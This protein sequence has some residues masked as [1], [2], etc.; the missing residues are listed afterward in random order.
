MIVKATNMQAVDWESDYQT[1]INPALINELLYKAVPALQASSWR[2]T[3]V[4]PGYCE[5]LLPLNEATTN[6]HGTHQAALIS[7][8]A[9]YTG[10]MALTTLLRGVPLS[11]IHHCQPAESAS[12]WLASMSVRYLN[13]STGHLTGR[14][15]VPEKEMQ[16]IVNRYSQGKRVL[17]TLPIEF[18]SN[19][20]RVAEAELAYFAQPTIQLLE[21]GRNPSALFSQKIKASARM[22]AGVRASSYGW[23]NGS[24]LRYDCPFSQ[25][26]AGPQGHLLAQKLKAALP[27]LP[28][29]VLARTQ[30]VDLTLRSIPGLQ[31]VILVGAGL[32]MRP[33]RLHAE[34]PQVEYFEIDL[35]P[36]LAERERVI[37]QF[38]DGHC[39]KR[40]AMAADFVLDD[41]AAVLGN[42]R[43]LN[44]HLPTAVVFEGCSM[45]FGRDV[46]E[47]ILRALRSVML[48]PESRLW[49]DYVTA[50]VVHGKT[51]FPEVAKFLERM[52]KLGE[53]FVFGQNSPAEFVDA[54]GFRSVETL[55]VQEFQQSLG[56]PSSDPV[57]DVYR[58]NVAAPG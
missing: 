41:L 15:R 7:L 57:L 10:G 34:L 54:C 3:E 39:V 19:G 5:S 30:H 47:R 25:L 21:P 37:Q 1:R 26:A 22:I 17:V 32:D 35:P 13:P 38:R 36:M 18:E 31:Q 40:T 2:I 46:N 28:E 48:H 14:C 43:G 42:C 12:L 56:Q 52:D 9:D 51:S 4:Q 24:M 33:F 55:S 16:T 27:Q 20:Q 8:S 58:F 45:Y 49:A 29:M 50:D 11:G 53:A 44:P 6:Q 23:A